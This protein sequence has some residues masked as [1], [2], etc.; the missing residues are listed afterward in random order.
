MS[1]LQRRGPLVV[2]MAVAAAAVL[3]AW[4]SPAAPPPTVT[5]YK[6]PSCGCCKAWMDHLQ[7]NGF[8]V[9]GKD[10]DNV[11]P[12]KD[13]LGVPSSLGSC[14]TAV[15]DGYVLEG[16]VPARE[17]HRLLKER[18]KV[19]GLSVPGMPMGS[20][21]MDGDRKDKYDVVAFDAK[22]RRTAFASY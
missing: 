17:V 7:Q 13:D 1:L 19:I 2:L 18:P 4:S 12:V 11:Q 14:H 6:S 22:G 20:P 16:H 9:V 8:R 21:G 10:M 3:G 15:V 5:V